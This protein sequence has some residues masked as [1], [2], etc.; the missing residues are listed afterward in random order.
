MIGVVHLVRHCNGLEP[1]RRFIQSYRVHPS[2]ADHELILLMKGVPAL[3][4]TPYLEILAGLPCHMIRMGDHG[5][6]LQTYG[7]FARMPP[8]DEYGVPDCDR[9]LFLNSF[10]EIAQDNWLKSFN[11]V[12]NLG[13]ALVG[14]TSSKESILTNSQRWLHR[15]FFQPFPNWHIRTNAFYITREIMLKVWPRRFYTK[16]GCYRFES[17][18]H[19]LCRRVLR[20]GY[21]TWSLS[22]GFRRG[23]SDIIIEDNQTRYYA[24]ASPK[25][26]Q[27]LRQLAW[28]VE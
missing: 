8:C 7:D 17:G 11:D 1:F 23:Q 14:A 28:G 16:Y 3:G 13:Y 26:K 24:E 4:L 18:K 10:S 6:D 21:A 27:R 20:L 22:R 15:F 25:E 5:Y 19:S 12:M 9:F 2:G